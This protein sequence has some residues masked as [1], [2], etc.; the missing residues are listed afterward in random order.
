MNQINLDPRTSE[1]FNLSL[2][3]ILENLL[4]DSSEQTKEKAF[5]DLQ[6]ISQKSFDLLMCESERESKQAL[7]A[8][9]CELIERLEE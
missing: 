6:A 1:Q 2:A 4:E 3:S 7:I 5:E 8:N 9:L